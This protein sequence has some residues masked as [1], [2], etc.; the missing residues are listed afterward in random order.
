MN[1]RSIGRESDAEPPLRTTAGPLEP[2]AVLWR[3]RR[4]IGQLTR[5]DIASRY[6]GSVFGILWSLLNPLFLLAAYTFVFT[7]IFKMKWNV[8]I[9]SK[10][11]FAIVVFAGMIVH[12]LFAE[13]A[14]R[15]PGL[16]LANANYVKRVVFPLEILPWTTV[17]SALFHTG[18]SFLVLLGFVFVESQQIQWTVVFAPVV[19]LPLAILTVG[20]CWIFAAVGVFLRDLG[21]VVG[22]LVTLL[23]FLSPVFYPLDAV[24]PEYR[25]IIYLNFLTLIIEQLRAVAIFGAMPDWRALAVY[26]VASIGVSWIGLYW[27]RRSKRGF[28]DVL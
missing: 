9:E 7:T 20:T 12:G 2:F 19:L 22:L 21:Y 28:A 25:E 10:S 24:P 8:G 23:L 11:Q 18:V 3:H 26:S 15:A 14:G 17:L 13:C 27:F 4:L 5:R 1:G 16:I 6:R